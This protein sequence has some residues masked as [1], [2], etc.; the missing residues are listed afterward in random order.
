MPRLRTLAAI[1]ALTLLPMAAGVILLT[2]NPTTVPREAVPPPAATTPAPVPA[3]TAPTR[4][5]LPTINQN[6]VWAS[7]TLLD[8]TTGELSRAGQTGTSTTES[9][10]KIAIVAQYLH[11][12]ETVG[13]TP[14]D[15][16]HA[17]LT[18]AI[19]DSDNTAA[20]TLY[21]RRGGN[22]MLTKA[23]TAC[24]L[25]ET[26]TKPGWWSETQMT[27]ADAARLGACIANGRICSTEWAAW[28]LAEMR[29]VRGEG[30][31]GIITS[32]PTD[33]GRP[34]AIKN[35]WTDR[36]DGWHVNC[37]AIADTWTMA[38]MVRYPLPLGLAHGAR[39]CADI[40]AAIAPT[41]TETAPATTTRVV[42]G[43]R[44]V[45][46]FEQ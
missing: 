11:D 26:S 46:L 42:A 33:H 21:R 27:S 15:A 10:I 45:E 12:L 5:P 32:R 39:L 18:Q 29:Q 34:L 7:W 30:R 36:P 16:E 24:D 4:T 37:L 23:I 1:G 8:R 44:I 9:M 19:R 13:R 14:T 31:F 25:R 38:V 43:A 2:A 3:V 40:A 6:Q 35:G 22:T 20:E 41:D 17:L 28:L